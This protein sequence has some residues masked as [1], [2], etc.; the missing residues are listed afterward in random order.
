MLAPLKRGLCMGATL[1]GWV[2]LAALL[3]LAAEAGYR[4]HLKAIARRPAKEG[5]GEGSG[6]VLTAALALLGLLIAFTFGMAADRY[7][8]R[9][10]LVVQEANAIS[11][12]V[13][14]YQ[15]LP[16]PQRDRLIAVMADYVK[17]RREFFEVGD[18]RDKVKA[19]EAR[20]EALQAVIWNDVAA[21]VR[22]PEGQPLTNLVIGTTNDMFDRAADRHAAFDARVPSRALHVLVLY[23]LV[24]AAIMGHSLA[25][26]GRRH[27]ISTS[28]LFVLIAMAISLII[29][30]DSPRMGGVRVPQAPLEHVADQVVAMAKTL[31]AAHPAPVTP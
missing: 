18:D 31:P 15:L 10:L 20:T 24:A 5:D 17:V 4:L 1:L 3:I 27:L 14:R 22:T 9:R 29:D 16:Q 2:L 8:T 11:T 25:P 26:G 7:E 6:Y 28:G 23:A 12:S 13:L 19:T 30:L 21:G